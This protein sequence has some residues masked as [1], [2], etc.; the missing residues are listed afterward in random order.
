M[1]LVQHVIVSYAISLAPK[2]HPFRDFL[3]DSVPWLWSED[4]NKV[5][6]ETK[7]KLS[8]SL[9]EGIMSFG[10]HGVPAATEA[11]FMPQKSRRLLQHPVLSRWVASLHGGVQVYPHYLASLLTRTWLPSTTPAW[12]VCP[13]SSGPC[14]SPASSWRDR[15]PV[16]VWCAPLH[17]Q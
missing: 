13:G 15:D 1:A 6:R 11:L 7:V 10:K 17:G 4:I 12:S 2:L 3:N 14:T 5:F 16:Q 9:E 8:D